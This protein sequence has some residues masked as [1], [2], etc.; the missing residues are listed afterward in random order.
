M[1]YDGDEWKLCESTCI[2]RLRDKG[3]EFMEE[4]YEEIKDKLPLTVKKTMERFNVHMDSEN[5]DSLKN[6][7]S[8]SIKVT[9]YN[10]R[11]K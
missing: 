7:M 8:K 9:L 2:D 1:V 3:I 10:N 6:N 11:P 4:Q 5:S